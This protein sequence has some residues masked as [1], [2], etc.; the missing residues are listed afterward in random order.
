MIVWRAYTSTLNSGEDHF[1]IYA[2]REA[3][4]RAC[5]VDRERYE[6]PDEEWTDGVGVY[7]IYAVPGRRYLKAEFNTI[8]VVD[9]EEVRE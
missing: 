4:M 1:G 3:A 2:T 5:E 9:P 6:L 8:Y 7:V